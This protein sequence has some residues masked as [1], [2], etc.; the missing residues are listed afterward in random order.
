MEHY[1]K[2]CFETRIQKHLNSNVFTACGKQYLMAM[3]AECCFIDLAVSD[4]QYN[5]KKKY[6]QRAV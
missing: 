1:L 2:T 4:M 5:I 3:F 6:M